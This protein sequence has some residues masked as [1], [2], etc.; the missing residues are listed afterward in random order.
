MDGYQSR[1]LFKYIC[2][3]IKTHWINIELYQWPV[4][5]NALL[6]D[7]GASKRTR[8]KKNGIGWYLAMGR[9]EIEHEHK[10]KAIYNNQRIAANTRI[11]AVM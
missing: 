8:R 7:G 2:Y 3:N 4:F 1:I 9:G 11:I 10:R 5:L 6:P